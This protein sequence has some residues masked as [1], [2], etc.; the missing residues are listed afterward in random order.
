MS[1]KNITIYLLL[2]QKYNFNTIII[3]KL[4]IKLYYIKLY[5]IYI[6]LFSKMYNLIINIF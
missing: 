5:Y 6:Y 1:K 2:N 4:I 3:I